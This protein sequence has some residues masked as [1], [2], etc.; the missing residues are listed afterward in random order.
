MDDENMTATQSSS[1]VDGDEYFD[2]YFDLNVHDVML[3]DTTRTLAYKNAIEQNQIDFKNKIVMDVGAGTGILSMFAAKCGAARVYAIEASPMAIYTE[4]LVE[5]NGLSDIITVI[6][7]RVENL[8]DDDFVDDIK[9]VDIIIS[10]WMGFYLLHESMLESVLDAR[11]RWLAPN[12][13]I[14]PTTGNIM[15]APVNLNKLMHDRVHHWDNVYGFDFSL[16]KDLSIHTL[17]S[18]P[19]IEYLDADS[20]LAPGRSLIEIDFRTVKKEELRDINIASMPFDISDDGCTV[21]HGFAIWFNC[22]FVGSQATV[23][24]DTAPGSPYTHW[25]QTTI[26][27]PQEID[28]KGFNHIDICLRMKQD[29]IN[30]RFYELSLSFPD[31]DDDQSN[32]NNE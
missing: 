1:E 12:G 29:D 17:H 13:I 25:K 10:E 26:L 30:P 15:I 27:L 2:S 7:K 31:D 11:D 28:I 23:R 20:V 14:F 5:A 9:K 32:T 4:R 22:Y 16:F 21:I 6:N 8:D 3:K 19:L 24:L 18:K